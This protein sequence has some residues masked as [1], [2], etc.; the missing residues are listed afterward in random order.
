MSFAFR[1]VRFPRKRVGGKPARQPRREAWQ[2]S[3]EVLED[4]T[5]PSL[6]FSQ[7]ANLSLT[8][9]VNCATPQSGGL[10]TFTIQVT[11][12]G[13]A[14]ATGVM[15]TDVLQNGLNIQ[16][17]HASQ[18][19]LTAL[20]PAETPNGP[21]GPSVVNWNIGSL[22]NGQTA[23]LTI[24]AE[25]GCC[26][27]LSDT[28][29]ITHSDQ[30]NCTCTPVTVT[31]TP[32]CPPPCPCPPPPECQCP[33]PPP[34]P[35]PPPPCPPPPCQQ[36]CSPCQTPP[37]C[38]QATCDNGCGQTAMCQPPPPCSQTSCDN[39]CTPTVT[40]QGGESGCP[41]TVCQTMPPCEVP[42]PCHQ[43]PCDD[44]ACPPVTC[45]PSHNDCITVA[46]QPPANPSPCT[47]ENDQGHGQ[48]V[49]M[50]TGD[51]SG[52][53]SQTMSTC[54]PPSCAANQEVCHQTMCLAPWAGQG[55]NEPS[56]RPCTAV[57]CTHGQ[58][59]DHIRQHKREVNHPAH[60]HPRGHCLTPHAIDN[61][62]VYRPE[63][64]GFYA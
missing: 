21:V 1:L 24:T 61:C 5:T 41:T 22:A 2:P 42:P 57:V 39:D 14:N 4:R 6:M 63:F 10:V 15:A 13:P 29:Q 20:A 54:P 47:S 19:S 31:V 23:T 34:C 56:C 38:N 49:C 53:S 55:Q 36:N 9:T 11:D 28:A 46:C 17:V 32:I 48:T 40:C 33:P 37:A 64:G 25:V 8:K 26:T 18:G 50:G 30:I 58:D 45:P 16:S 35:C 7:M 52:C 62:F 51:H 60:H 27:P 59:H 43:A 44:N 3:L 12:N